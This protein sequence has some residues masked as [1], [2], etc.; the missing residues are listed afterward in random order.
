MKRGLENLKSQLSDTN[1]VEELA[2]LIV[3]ME[4]VESALLEETVARKAADGRV[5]T[6]ESQVVALLPLTDRLASLESAFTAHKML[7][8]DAKVSVLVCVFCGGVWCRVLVLRCL[9]W[10]GLGCKV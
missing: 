6:L 5:A 2:T 3:S 10:S 1:V 9:Q 7:G 8:P 4:T